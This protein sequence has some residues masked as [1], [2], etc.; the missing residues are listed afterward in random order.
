M[1]LGVT[2]P[3][4]FAGKAYEEE[5]EREG[6]PST[7]LEYLDLLADVFCECV[8]KLEPGGSSGRRERGLVAR[9]LGDRSEAPLTRSFVI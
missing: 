5:L 1:A 9:A 2:S 7:Y 4:Y 8:R 6:V 3:P